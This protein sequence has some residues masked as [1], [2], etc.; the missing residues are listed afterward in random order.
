[1]RGRKAS[2]FAFLLVAAFIL[3]AG[4]A[5]AQSLNDA[6]ASAYQSNPVLQAARAQL[7]STDEQ[8]PE[9]LSGW[10]PTANAEAAAGAG[11]DN[12]HEN[13]RVLGLAQ[14]RITQPIYRGGR[15]APR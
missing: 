9:A 10:R 14:L 8:V 7:R 4:P 11:I 1:M 15:P 5:A 6:L 3:P 13:G 12:N 2:S